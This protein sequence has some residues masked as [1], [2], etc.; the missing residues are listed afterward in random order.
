MKFKQFAYY[1]FA[2]SGFLALAFGMS[3]C[4][5]QSK[6]L[7]LGGVIGAGTGAVLGGI[8]DPGKDGEY[9]TRNVI[10]KTINLK[11]TFLGLA[12]NF[13]VNFSFRFIHTLKN[14]TREIGMTLK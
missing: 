1:L 2:W 11:I 13:G 9:R 10:I 7:A 3:G 8:A 5:T 4:A 14:S 6:S 12:Q